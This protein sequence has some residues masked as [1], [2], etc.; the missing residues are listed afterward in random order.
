MS[1]KESDTRCSVESCRN[2]LN[3]VAVFQ[4][5]NS[6]AGCHGR[7]AISHVMG[8]KEPPGCAFLDKKH[9]G[10]YNTGKQIHKN[11]KAKNDNVGQQSRPPDTG[12]A[13]SPSGCIGCMIVSRIISDPVGMTCIVRHA[14]VGVPYGCGAEMRAAGSRSCGDN[15]RVLQGRTKARTVVC[16]PRTIIYGRTMIG[17]SKI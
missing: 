4:R 2:M 9:A 17:V 3:I 10:K 14:G 16:A 11:L 7:R 6:L 15:D 8:K 13:R 12:C 5:V 1:G